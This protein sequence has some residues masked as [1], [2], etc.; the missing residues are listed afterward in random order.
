MKSKFFLCFGLGVLVLI[1]KGIHSIY[2]FTNDFKVAYIT[3]HLA[4]H[5]EWDISGQP[6]IHELRPL[7]ARP[8]KYLGKGGQAYAFESDDGQYVLKF[9]RFKFLQPRLKLQLISWIPFLEDWDI[10]ERERRLRKVHDFYLGYKKAFEVNHLNSGLI[11]LHFNPT[12]NQFGSV[13]IIDRKGLR[14]I[15]DLDQTVFILQKKADMLNDLLTRLLKQGDLNAAKEKIKAMLEM[16]VHHYK[17][18]LHD[19]G[20]GVIH[21]TGFVGDLPIHVDLGK[22]A[23]DDEIKVPKSYQADLRLVADKIKGWIGQFHPSQAQELHPFIDQQV[24]SL[25]SAY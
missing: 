21:N 10:N 13:E 3:T 8:F 18:G 17:M 14:H 9:V 25:V 20:Y 19:L 23:F 12:F 7:L 22:M 6:T 1:F 5:P 2:H 16:Y 11:Y 24:F 4:Y 15:V